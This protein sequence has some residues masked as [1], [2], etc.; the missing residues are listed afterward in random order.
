M[1]GE[2]ATLCELMLQTAQRHGDRPAL[3]WQ[4][5]GRWQQLGWAQYRGRVLELAA[6]LGS[7]GVRRG[8]VVAIMAANRPEHAMAAFAAMHAGAT[9]S[10]FYSTLAPEQIR[11]AADNCRARVAILENQEVLDRWEAVRAELPD[12]EHVV[13]IDAAGARGEVIA[14]EELLRR[15]RQAPAQEA[16]REL[17]PEDPA[18]LIYTS[19]TTGPP[20]GVPLSHRNCLWEARTLVQ[21]TDLPMHLRTICYLPLAHIAEQMVSLYLCME[22]AGNVYFCPEVTQALEVVRAARPTGFFAVPR[23]WEKI[24]GAV[25]RR[26]EQARPLQRALARSALQA[27]SECVRWH[28]KGQRPPP[29]LRLRAALLDR[30]VLSKIRQAIGLQKCQVAASGAAPLPVDVA[31]FFA[32]IGLPIVELS[33]M[34]E[35]T[36]VATA[37]P[38]RRVK[39]GTVG[40]ALP[41]VEV[42]LAEDGEL[43][44]RGPNCMHHGYLNQPEQTAELIDAD[45]WLH[46]GDIGVKD[47]EGYFRIVDRKKELIITAGGKNISPANIECLLKEHPLIGQ[48]L[49]YGDRKPFVVGLLVLDGEAARD[50]ARA[51]GLDGASIAELARHPLLREEL[52]RAVEAVNSRLSRVEQVK[53]FDILPTEWTAESEELTP[54]LKLRRKVVHEKYRAEIEALYLS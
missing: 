11:F 6:G 17:R 16:W 35:T 53:K 20:K 12:L 40:P 52:Q 39:V 9:P 45:G 32:A 14:W 43:L 5:H 22:R 18:T 31:A 46:T 30:L 13:L 23:V 26:L 28:E 29:G 50:W 24:H 44:V 27:G 33:G 1:K 15:G 38:R 19:G 3:S 8:D 37:N 7:L 49:A 47:A 25:L 41:G 2:V 4:E 42:K 51:H 21:V 36:G 10:T 54:T 48:A 34:T